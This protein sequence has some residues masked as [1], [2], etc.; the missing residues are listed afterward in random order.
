MPPGKRTGGMVNIGRHGDPMPKKAYP[1]PVAL[2]RSQIG[3]PYVWAHPLN[4]ANPNPR[5]FDCSGLV[6]WAW[7]HAGGQKFPFHNS[8]EMYLQLK[9]QGKTRPYAERQPG[10]AVFYND[11][12][13]IHHVAMVDYDINSMVTADDVGI[14]VR[15]TGIRT[16]GLMHEVG[17]FTSKGLTDIGGPIGAPTGIGRVISDAAGVDSAAVSGWNSVTGFLGNLMSGA[18]LLRAGEVVLGIIVVGV[19]VDKLAKG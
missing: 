17:V 15:V 8:A 13:V 14:P 9:A 10:D 7:W 5:S 18:F 19:A 6:E 12:G 3:K 16:F 11:G 2:A 4:L 1:S